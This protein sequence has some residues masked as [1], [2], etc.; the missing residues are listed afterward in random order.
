MVLIGKTSA[1]AA[2]PGGF[3]LRSMTAAALLVAMRGLAG[4]GGWAD[5][6]EWFGDEDAASAPVPSG[7]ISRDAGTNADR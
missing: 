3:M 1:S 4:C 2:A 6:T 5:P 7:S